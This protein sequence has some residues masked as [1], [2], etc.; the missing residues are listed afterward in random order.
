MNGQEMCRTWL[1]EKSLFL[2]AET[3]GLDTRAEVVEVAIAD[4]KGRPVFESLVNVPE[5]HRAL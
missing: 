2:D 1:N 4:S 5:P 3:T